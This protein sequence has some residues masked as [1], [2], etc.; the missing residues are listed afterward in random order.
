MK[1][2]TADDVA[3]MLGVPSSWLYAQ[4]RRNAIPHVRLGR[5]VRFDPSDVE[6]WIA[7]QKTTNGAKG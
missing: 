7:E 1:L 3:A 6:R 5:Y 4:A 2:V